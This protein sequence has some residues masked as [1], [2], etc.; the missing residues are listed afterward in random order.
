MA[1]IRTVKPEFW[2]DEK[3]APLPDS[4]RLLFLGMI[5]MA[6]DYGRLLDSPKQIEA[7]V[8]PCADRSRDCRE[9]LASLSR[10]GRILRGLTASGQAVIQITNWA[11]HQR[12]DKPS[13]KS[14]LPELVA[15]PLFTSTDP[16]KNGNSRE[17]LA[18]D[19]RSDLDLDLDRGATTPEQ[20]SATN[21][22][23]A[24]TA[25][26][27]LTVC[28]NKAIAS[29]FGEQ[30]DPLVSGGGRSVAL[31]EAVLSA[32]IPVDF[33]GRSIARQVQ[34][35][36]TKPV[37]SMWYFRGGIVDDWQKHNERIA[38][39]ASNAVK[40]LERSARGGDPSL[41]GALLRPKHD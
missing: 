7:F 34:D 33:A 27:E 24:T 14:A 28:A 40:P 18:K 25:A 30:A 15:P 9:G 21:T 8:W 2:S 17:T 38:A 29:R 41:I 3:L 1:R 12:V 36:L 4:V 11:R 13:V 39:A 37:R 31:A 22:P 35:T 23:D 16:P 6:D 19:S 20:R 10:L 26:T 5:S 32:G